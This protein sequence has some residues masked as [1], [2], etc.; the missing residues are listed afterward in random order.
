MTGS[1]PFS[2]KES[3]NFKRSFKKLAKVHRNK[4]V[5][6]IGEILENLIEDQY[7]RN[8][9]QEPLPGHINLPEGWTFHKLEIRISKGASGQIRLMY[10]VNEATSIIRLVWIYSHEQ[11][12]KRP[13]DKD[14]KNVIKRTLD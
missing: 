6:V 14:L 9:R 7:P 13:A 2:I 10:L 8:S 5:E 3:E 4:L 12:S 11:F 1:T